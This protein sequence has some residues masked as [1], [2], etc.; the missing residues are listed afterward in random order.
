M[1]ITRSPAARRRPVVSDLVTALS[2][3]ATM[4]I[5]FYAL[6]PAGAPA[7]PEATMRETGCWSDP[8]S[9][10]A[11]LACGEHAARIRA[12]RVVVAAR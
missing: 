1:S 10:E 4:A 5:L 8:M 9:D 12:D 11:P 3:T 7:Q 6:V 2:I